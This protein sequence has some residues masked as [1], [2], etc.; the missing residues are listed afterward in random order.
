MTAPAPVPDG[1]VHRL[2]KARRNTL[3]ASLVPRL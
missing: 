2:R 1:G 3:G